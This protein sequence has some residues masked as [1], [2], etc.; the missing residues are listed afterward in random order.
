MKFASI[1]LSPHGSCWWLKTHS[2]KLVTVF[3]HLDGKP[4]CVRIGVRKV[5]SEGKTIPRPESVIGAA[6]RAVQS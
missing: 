5:W 2:G 6:L 4:Y 3:R 1:E